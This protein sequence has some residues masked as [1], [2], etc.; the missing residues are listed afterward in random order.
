MRGAL[1]LSGALFFAVI[2]DSC[3]SQDLEY[4]EPF[5]FEINIEIP[6]VEIDADIPAVVAPSIPSVQAS[7]AAQ[8]LTSQVSA[9]TNPAD[10]PTSVKS[11]LSTAASVATTGGV[12]TTQVQSFNKNGLTTIASTPPSQLDQTILNASVAAAQ[13]PS[14]KSLFPTLSAPA[15]RIAAAEPANGSSGP[16]NGSNPVVAV[17]PPGLCNAFYPTFKQSELVAGGSNSIDVCSGRCGQIQCFDEI[18]GIC[19]DKSREQFGAAFTEGRAY[20]NG[21][22]GA[23]LDEIYNPL[24][25]AI[26]GRKTTRDN[27]AKATF[28]A[29]VL[30]V[31]NQVKDLIDASD[32]FLVVANQS[33]NPADLEVANNVRF[34]AMLYF[35]YSY[36]K[37]Y[38]AYQSTL[39]ING[40]AA[41][42]EDDDLDK[43]KVRAFNNLEFKFWDE[44][45]FKIEDAFIKA[46][47]NCH[48]QG[49]GN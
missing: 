13:N 30:A 3:K 42:K 39:T 45:I 18:T 29:G 10:V 38:E 4:I 26:P 36:S 48:N 46:I 7:A 5:N 17:L 41:V 1:L 33:G 25:S 28:D 34:F 24:F 47:G 32:R 2:L 22:Q 15:A 37:A 16:N 27:T 8:Q 35:Y 44:V 49:T 19:A 12:T 14:I 9:S 43:A 31:T 40:Q 6:E 23:G 20:I 21:L 11:S